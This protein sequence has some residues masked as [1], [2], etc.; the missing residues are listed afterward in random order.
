MGNVDVYFSHFPH[1]D[2]VGG[3]M[4]P[5]VSLLTTQDIVL[6]RRVTEIWSQ[7]PE[8]KGALRLESVVRGRDRKQGVHSL[9][10]D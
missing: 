8:P 4:E 5:R 6:W 9:A 10:L 1:E 7:T 3:Q 2:V